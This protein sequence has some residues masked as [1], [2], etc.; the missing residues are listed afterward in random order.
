MGGYDGALRTFLH[1]LLA[2]PHLD[3]KTNNNLIS[4]LV[5]LRQPLSGRSQITI[6][7]INRLEYDNCHKQIIL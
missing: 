7:F 1:P 6:A 2:R 3:G 4:M 5:S